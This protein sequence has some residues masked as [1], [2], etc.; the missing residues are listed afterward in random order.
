MELNDEFHRIVVRASGSPRVLAALQAVA[1]IPR[2]F[3]AVF[4]SSEEQ[5]ARSLFCHRQILAAL[6]L[7]QPESAG[8]AMRL[9][10]VQ[11]REFLVSLAGDESGQDG[12]GVSAA[13]P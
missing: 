11:A 6:E 3:R 5:R 10:V 8:L 9:H 7:R 12:A 13:S 4:W 1:G 2:P